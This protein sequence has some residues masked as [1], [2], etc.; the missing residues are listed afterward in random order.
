MRGRPALDEP[1][2]TAFAVGLKLFGKVMLERPHQPLF[3]E[4]RPQ[5][6]VFVKRSKGSEPS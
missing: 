3:E 4:M 1:T 6:P 5:F 2:A